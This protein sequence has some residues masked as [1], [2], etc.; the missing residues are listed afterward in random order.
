M[1]ISRVSQPEIT[2]TFKVYVSDV[3]PFL[4]GSIVATNRQFTQD[5]YNE[6]KSLN[7][8]TKK[9]SA[10]KNEKL[11]S[12]IV[13]YT[14]SLGL[15]EVKVSV[16]DLI[17][18]E[19][20][21]DANNIKTSY[22]KSTKAYDGRF[23]GYGANNRKPVPEATLDNRKESNDIL[24]QDKLTA[25]ASNSL[26]PVWIEFN[27]PNNAQAGIYKTKLSVTAKEITEPI[28]FEYEIEVLDVELDDI[29]KFRNQFDIELWQYPYSSAEHY[30]YEPFSLE[31]KE[32]LKSHMNLYKSIGGHAIT[33]TIVE[34]P[35][36]A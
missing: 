30:G 17:N 13:L 2:D 28:E 27:I 6:I 10:W 8:D 19:S 22:V 25:I 5:K 20:R 26:Q 11:N 15:T 35:W 29:S 31:H 9:I 18:S 4:G 32:V 36:Q 34:E 14:K 1:T 33:A 16:G 7:V 23:L 3:K 24:Y 12:E 21:I